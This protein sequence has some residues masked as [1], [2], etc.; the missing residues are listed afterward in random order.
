MFSIE[1]TED[2]KILKELTK[3]ID[4]KRIK[5]IEE[6]LLELSSIN[7]KVNEMSEL[8]DKQNFVIEKQNTVIQKIMKNNITADKCRDIVFDLLANKSQ[9]NNLTKDKKLK[10][11]QHE[12]NEKFVFTE[13]MKKKFNKLIVKGNDLI[14]ITKINQQMDFPVSVLQFLA[15]VEVYQ[16]KKGSFTNEDARNFCK[17]YNINKVQFGRIYYNLKEG[18]F[19]S[20]INEIDK[21]IRQTSFAIKDD[22]INI[23]EGGQSINTKVDIKTFND[24]LN[25]YV[26]SKQPYSAVYKLSREYRNINPIHLLAIL[27]RNENVSKLIA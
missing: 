16:Y 20:I 15:L 26:N 24:L 17:L 22:F 19:F 27:R 13:V 1:T 12:E 14:H 23:V 5:V 2:V 7:D 3:N 4:D 10:I 21:Q 6:Q 18:V 25:I 8:I 9:K 11:I